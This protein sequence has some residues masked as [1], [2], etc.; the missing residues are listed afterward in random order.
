[1]TSKEELL[2]PMFYKNIGEQPFYLLWLLALPGSWDAEHKSMK[3][4]L[5]G[6]SEP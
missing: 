2:C 4:N 5:Q 6:K 3:N 1:M